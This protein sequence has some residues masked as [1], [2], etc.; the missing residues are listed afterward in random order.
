MPLQTAHRPTYVTTNALDC[1]RRR[2]PDLRCCI[3]VPHTQVLKVPALV[4]RCFRLA[5]FCTQHQFGDSWQDQYPVQARS[6]EG[7]CLS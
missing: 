2:R 3:V 7:G 4:R 5:R 1:W 6:D